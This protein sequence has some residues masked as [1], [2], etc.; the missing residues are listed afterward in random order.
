MKLQNLREAKNIF[1][2]T[3]KDPIVKEYLLEL[4]R[5]HEETYY[6]TLRVCFLSLDIAISNGY[7]KNDLK[8]LSYAGIF[9]DIGKLNIAPEILSKKALN[10]EDWKVFKESQRKAFMSLKYLEMDN[11]SQ[12]VV[13]KYE[14]NRNKP[15]PRKSPDRRKRRRLDCRER[16][17]NEKKIEIFSQIISVA[18]MF[19]KYYYKLNNRNVERGAL[20]N[21]L[22]DEFCG[23]KNYVNEILQRI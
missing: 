5:H 19:E 12:I 22:N 6:H 21:Y 20:L 1:L 2:T 13:A 11:V 17:E 9:Q 7:K 23:N 3:C 10:S 16:R 14:Y 15:F 4:K 8:T 18:D